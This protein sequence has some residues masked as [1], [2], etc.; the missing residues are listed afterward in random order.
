MVLISGSVVI[1]IVC[2]ERPVSP[3]SRGGGWT[4]RSKNNLNKENESRERRHTR[5]RIARFVPGE[6]QRFALSSAEASYNHALTARSTLRIEGKNKA[7]PFTAPQ[8]SLSPLF[9][10]WNLSRG[11]SVLV[12][13]IFKRKESDLFAEYMVWLVEF[14]CICISSST[15]FARKHT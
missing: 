7:R 12:I 15:L 1:S 8:F 14:G 9:T 13:K 11:E 4:A 2:N 3:G 5:A 6:Y 10:N